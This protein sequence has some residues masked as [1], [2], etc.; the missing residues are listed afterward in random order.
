M[1]NLTHRALVTY[2]QR[3]TYTR[4]VGNHWFREWLTKHKET[5]W[6]NES[7]HLSNIVSKLKIFSLKQIWNIIRKTFIVLQDGCVIFAISTFIVPADW[8]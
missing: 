5:I 8:T 2:T 3:Y 4:E 7:M 1:A 6:V